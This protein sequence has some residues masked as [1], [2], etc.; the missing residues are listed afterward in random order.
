MAQPMGLT[1]DDVVF[2]EATPEQQRIALGLRAEACPA[3][4]GF[5]ERERHLTQH[6]LTQSSRRQW[7]L[8]LKG[9]PRQIIASCE[10]TRQKIFVSDDSAREAYGY[11]IRHVFTTPVWRRLGMAAYLLRYVKERMDEDSECS[12]FFSDS[13]REYYTGLGWLPYQGKQA[14]LILLSLPQSRPLTPVESPTQFPEEGSRS[15]APSFSYRPTGLVDAVTVDLLRIEDLPWL[16]KQDNYQLGARFKNMSPSKKTHV[17]FA[18][19]YARLEWQ[20]ARAEFDAV[21]MTGRTIPYKGAKTANS[22]SWLYWAHDI[23]AKKLRILRIVH[24]AER[25]TAAQ[26]IADTQVLLEAAL[27]EAKDWGLPR[28]VLWNPDEDIVTG[29]KAV[30]NRNTASVKVVFDQQMGGCVPS[31]RWKP[32]EPGELGRMIEWEDNYGY[33]LP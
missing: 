18:P 17:A 29:C 32:S 1:L 13:G 21:R 26:R 24:G 7:V 31:L 20:L 12:V 6:E 22:R 8:Y 27:A 28:V 19:T 30:G 14:N 16:C 3:P 25:Q 33:C 11:T 4:D 2:D 10:A 9:Y 5:I 23:P 15:R